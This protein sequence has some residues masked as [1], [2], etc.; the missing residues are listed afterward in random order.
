MLTVN[1]EHFRQKIQ[2]TRLIKRLQDHAFGRVDMQISA[3]RAAI[4]LLNKIVPDLVSSEIKGEWTHR[5]VLEV[6]TTAL[7]SAQWEAE[8]IEPAPIEQTKGTKL[9]PTIEAEAE[10]S[11]A[12]KH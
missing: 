5:Y 10:N 4:A 7:S 12:S 3:V 6:P 9:A 8:T 2:G 1:P 11:E